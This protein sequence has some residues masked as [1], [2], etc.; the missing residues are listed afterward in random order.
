MRK[1]RDKNGNQTR[2]QLP[3]GGEILREY[4]A[5]DRLITET[6]KEKKSKIHNTTHFAYD[7]AG[8]LIEITDNQGRKTKNEY[9]LLNREIRRIERNGG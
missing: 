3:S 6:H 9:D 4:D 8:N 2:I 5:A 7:K 1:K